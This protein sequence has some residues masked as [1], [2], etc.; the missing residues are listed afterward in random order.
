MYPQSS[1]LVGVPPTAVTSFFNPQEIFSIS[2]LK[3][4]DLSE[5]MLP[6][7]FVPSYIL[8]SLRSQSLRSS[9]SKSQVS[10][11]TLILKYIKSQCMI[12]NQYI[13]RIRF[14]LPLPMVFFGN[15]TY[16]KITSFFIKVYLNGTCC[17]FNTKI[18]ITV[19][20]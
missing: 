19:V 4:D 11:S 1:P 15:A 17:P 20:F 2:V 3:Q 8:A 14:I 12:R 13:S 5:K 10:C 7:G 18:I 9:V 16:F 6:I